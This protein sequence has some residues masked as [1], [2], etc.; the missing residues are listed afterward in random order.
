[1]RDDMGKRDEAAIAGLAVIAAITMLGYMV[2]ITL[3]AAM[4]YHP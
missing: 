1:M 4:E 3:L 2:A